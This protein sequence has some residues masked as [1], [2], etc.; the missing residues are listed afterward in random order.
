MGFEKNETGILQKIHDEDEIRTHASEE[1]TTLTWRVRPLR[2][3]TM[4]SLP[5]NPHLLCL[6]VPLAQQRR[7][8]VRD[9]MGGKKEMRWQRKERSTWHV[10]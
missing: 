7:K 8:G 10:L 9:N 2:H 3:F 6:S 4:Y 5:Q 1:T